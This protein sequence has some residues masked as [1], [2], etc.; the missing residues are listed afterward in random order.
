MSNGN[1]L[2]SLNAPSKTSTNGIWNLKEQHAYNKQEL[3]PDRYM[4]LNFVPSGGIT[5]ARNGTTSV[6]ISKTGG[7][8][9]S[10]D[11]GAHTAA[12]YSQ[13]LTLE[14]NKTASAGDDGLSYAMIGL[15]AD[16]AASNGYDTIDHASYPFQQNSYTIYNNGSGADVGGSWSQSNKFYLVYADNTIKHYNGSKL[17][18]TAAYTANPVGI[19]SSLYRVNQTNC[20]FTNVRLTQ[21]V[22]NGTEYA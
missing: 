11:Q 9:S 17:L 7:T 13:P 16:P 8:D 15:N 19:D 2:G 20:R 12:T 22:W 5:I 4:V 1:L 18:Y 21:S 3:W 6:D 14:F 10:W